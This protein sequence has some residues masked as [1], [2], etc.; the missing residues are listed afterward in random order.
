VLRV[1]LY[2]I[3]ETTNNNY[4]RLM[5]I[6]RNEL[7]YSGQTI[8]V[9]IDVHL[10][11]W[12]V[13]ILTEHLHHKTFTQPSDPCALVSY[14]KNNLPGS[15]YQSAYEAGFSGLWT[16]YELTKMGVKNI[17][18]NPFDVPSTQKEHLQ[19]TDSMDSRKIACS[20]LLRFSVICLQYK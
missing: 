16:H 13:T 2:L 10:K 17:V 5:P 14:L 1:L 4:S 9:G 19:K 6:Q 11:S 20:L 18:V 7:N 3:S 15:S 8:Y 12:S